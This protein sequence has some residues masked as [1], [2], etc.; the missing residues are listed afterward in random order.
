MLSRPSQEGKL[1]M[2]KKPKGRKIV[3]LKSRARRISR[4]RVRVLL[5]GDSSTLIRRYREY[6]EAA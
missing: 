5:A 3:A 2:T 6:K 1:K 4:F